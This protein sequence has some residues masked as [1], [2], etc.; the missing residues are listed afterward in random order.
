M[1]IFRSKITQN[2]PKTHCSVTFIDI[3]GDI[4]GGEEG[5]EVGTGEAAVGVIRMSGAE[6][7]HA[8]VETKEDSGAVL[9]GV[10][11]AV[12]E[13]TQVSA[14]TGVD[15]LLDDADVTEGEVGQIA[16]DV[17]ALLVVI[18]YADESAGDD[19]VAVSPAIGRA[20]IGWRAAVGIAA[21]GAA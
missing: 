21:I 4:V 20:E 6:L 12:A 16:V 3:A 13:L 5:E 15:P 14:V 19:D 9:G 11:A 10:D 8:V 18:R 1:D 17:V 7:C 2:Y